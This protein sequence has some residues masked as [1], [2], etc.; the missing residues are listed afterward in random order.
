M[1]RAEVESATGLSRSTIYQRIKAGTFPK[2]VH[3]GA[4]SVGWRV[5]DIDAFL[6]SPADYTAPTSGF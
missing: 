2:P 6:S 1:R 4:R 5:A 3:L